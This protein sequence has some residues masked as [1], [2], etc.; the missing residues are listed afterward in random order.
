MSVSNVAWFVGLDLGQSQD[1]SAIAVIERARVCAYPDPER[2]W[3]GE[4]R[5]TSTAYDVR[6]LERPKLGTPYL[7]VC[8]RSAELV[9]ALTPRGRVELVVDATGVGRAVLEMLRPLIR[10]PLLEVTI[11][12][13]EEER[14]CGGGR[15]HVPKRDLVAGVSAELGAKQLRVA[16][17]LPDA[18]VLLQELRQFRMKI[19]A[20]GRDTYSAWREGDHDDLVLAVALA[21]WRA[22]RVVKPVNGARRLLSF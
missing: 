20:A 7:D 5:L 19:S 17:A 9:D 4:L 15:W 8:R 11:T 16:A 6:H 3:N 21:L 14:A 2:P 10:C 18:A 1:P 13:G 12:T 22:R